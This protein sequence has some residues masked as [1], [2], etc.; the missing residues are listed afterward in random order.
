[1]MRMTARLRLENAARYY[2]K[3][4]AVKLDELERAV[5][6]FQNVLQLEVT[7]VSVPLADIDDKFDLGGES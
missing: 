1:M 4:D 6:A 5:V 7:A 3:S 2:V